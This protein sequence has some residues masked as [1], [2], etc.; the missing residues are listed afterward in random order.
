MN[1]AQERYQLMFIVHV[2]PCN[3]TYHMYAITAILPSNLGYL[4]SNF[5]IPT[6]SR[7]PSSFFCKQELFNKMVILI[8]M[9]Y[10]EL[11]YNVIDYIIIAIMKAFFIIINLIR[12]FPIPRMYLV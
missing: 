3:A 11:T 8:Y 6:F 5:N 1:I 7:E 4:H 12:L 2:I 9:E 10:T